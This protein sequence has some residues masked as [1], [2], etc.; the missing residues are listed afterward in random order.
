[1]KWNSWNS[2]FVLCSKADEWIRN[3]PSHRH[4]YTFCVY[5]QTMNVLTTFLCRPV[6]NRSKKWR[7]NGL[8]GVTN[9]KP[10]LFQYH[11]KRMEGLAEDPIWWARG[12]RQKNN[13]RLTCRSFCYHCVTE[14]NRLEL[15]S[16]LNA[17]LWTL[18][19]SKSFS[20][21]LIEA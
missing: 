8:T 13:H 5:R 14:A 9:E 15:L 3:Q 21:K 20:T 10:A 17:M 2:L 19:P 6:E 1:M 4:L 7:M 16:T 11:S 18:R 12:K